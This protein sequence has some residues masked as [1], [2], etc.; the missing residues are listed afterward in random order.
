MKLQKEY[1]KGMWEFYGRICF[2]SG[3]KSGIVEVQRSNTNAFVL[4]TVNALVWRFERRPSLI[5]ITQ[6]MIN[7][8]DERLKWQNAISELGRK[9]YRNLRN[10][11]KRTTGSPRKYTMIISV[12]R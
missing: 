8:M 12:A 11:L 6:Q 2:A 5:R 1:Q 3:C 7:K 9:N 10:V 4:V